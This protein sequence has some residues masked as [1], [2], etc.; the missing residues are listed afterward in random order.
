VKAL[1]RF[2]TVLLLLGN[3]AM[4]AALS[5]HVVRAP[6][7]FAVLPKSQLTLLETYVDTREWSAADL[8]DHVAVVARLVQSGHAAMLSHV[9]GASAAATQTPTEQKVT[10]AA[11]PQPAPSDPPHQKTIFDFPE[12]K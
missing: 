4:L 12:Q 5:L 6:G 2:L 11:K 3:L 7:Q 9:T 1:A 10:D 8:H